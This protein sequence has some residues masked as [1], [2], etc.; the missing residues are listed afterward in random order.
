MKFTTKILAAAAAAFVGIVAVSSYDASP[1]LSA[2][3]QSR[4]G[5]TKT[6]TRQVSKMNPAGLAKVGSMVS[7]LVGPDATPAQYRKVANEVACMNAIQNDNL[8]L[9]NH[10]CANVEWYGPNREIFLPG[11]QGAI[12]D[13]L[14][15]ELPG[16]FGF[17]PFG[18][19]R[20]DLAQ[21]AEDE[22]YHGRW[23][24]LAAAGI[25]VPDLL[26]KTGMNIEPKWWNVGQELLQG[27]PIDYLG[28]PNLIHASNFGAIFATQFF[29]MASAEVYR[30]YWETEEGAKG[31]YPGGAFDPLNFA[32]DPAK[33][34]ELKIKEIKN[35]RLAMLAM[36]GF[37]AQAFSTGKT[38][39]QNLGDHISNP[40]VNH[41]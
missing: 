14:K 22:L 30:G 34:Q 39:L 33:F 2:A 23:A 38:P 3:M 24:M 12:P 5:L 13:H 8:F 36:L 37:Y 20:D 32:K 10:A 11:K 1:K 26:A 9:K 29:L 6:V 40:F 4:S 7:K 15:G 41:I 18:F 17:D 25:L 28:N 21:R 16:D 31:M 19:G 27:K 35:G